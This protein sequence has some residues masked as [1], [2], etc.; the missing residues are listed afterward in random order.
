MSFGLNAKTDPEIGAAALRKIL[1]FQPPGDYV[2]QRK[3]LM[4]TT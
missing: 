4:I 3:D 1:R 2:M